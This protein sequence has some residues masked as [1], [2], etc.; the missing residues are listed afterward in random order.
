MTSNCIFC[1]ALANSD[2]HAFPQWLMKRFIGQGLVEHQRNLH[3]VPRTKRD[4][5]LRIKL[6]SVCKKCN[7]EWMNRLQERSRPIIESLLDCPSCTVD[8]Y[9]C[10][11]LAL[12]AVMSA[13]VLETTNEPEVWRFTDTERC[14]FYTREEIPPFTLVWI[15]TWSDSPGPSYASRVLGDKSDRA[16][17]TTFGFGTLIFQVLKVVPCDATGIKAMDLRPGLPWGQIML[18]VWK[19][20]AVPVCWPPPM[21][22]R[23]EAELEALELRFSRLGAED[24]DT[25]L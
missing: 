13:M 24:S 25:K 15:A 12:W 17:V 5:R 11:T 22:I 21:P 4:D 23:G 2:E 3:A 1:N 9:Q 14:L 20:Q 10:K 7:S 18:Q 8:I 19:P 16:T 6:K